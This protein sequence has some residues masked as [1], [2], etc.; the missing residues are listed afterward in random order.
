MAAGNPA[1]AVHRSLA[2]Y[3]PVPGMPVVP[4]NPATQALAAAQQQELLFRELLS[5]AP[6]VNDP[7]LTQQVSKA[8]Y[9]MIRKVK[10]DLYRVYNNCRSHTV[11]IVCRSIL[12]CVTAV[13]IALT[14][15]TSG[16][17]CMFLCATVESRYIELGY[18][19]VSLISNRCQRPGD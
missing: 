16:L 19:E 9:I 1:S 15:L 2:A 4:A 13:V 14:T 18:F 6:H 7:V 11:L 12:T 10:Q 17:C 8:K 3:G 5:R